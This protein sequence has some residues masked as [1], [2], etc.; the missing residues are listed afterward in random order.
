MT[1]LSGDLERDG[2]ENWTYLYESSNGMSSE[3]VS[4]MI[5]CNLRNHKHTSA[6]V[7]HRYRYYYFRYLH[8]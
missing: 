7:D 8:P 2:D 1:V 4:H 5:Y 3:S 6:N